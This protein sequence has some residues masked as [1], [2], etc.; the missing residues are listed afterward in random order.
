MALNRL[1]EMGQDAW[2]ELDSL[3]VHRFTQVG[4]LI[5]DDESTFSGPEAFEVFDR[6]RPGP[7]LALGRWI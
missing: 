3:G 6:V 1:G 5:R 4:S 2:H 7:N